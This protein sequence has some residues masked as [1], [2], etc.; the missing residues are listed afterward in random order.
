MTF[1]K[2]IIFDS[3]SLIS[4]TMAGLIPE[5]RGLKKIFKGKF[6]ITNEVKQ[7]LVDKPMNNKRFELEAMKIQQLLDEKILELPISLGI[8]NS[9]I[10]NEGKKFS[11]IAN[12]TFSTRKGPVKLIHVGESSSLALS[13]I[14]TRKGI[15]NVIA[16]DERTTRM[17]GEKPEN[18]KK[19]M[20]KK[21]HMSIKTNTQNYKFFKG[22]NFIRS[23]ELVYVA[24]KK[25]I[26]R[27]KKGPVLDALLYALKFKGAAISSDEI[28]EIKRIN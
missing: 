11:D 13:K 4:F 10:T 6:L 19:L 9:E 17:L 28:N 25:K 7:E 16:I 22:F 26:V 2:S 14:L 20:E 3:G 23:P 18:L 12:N 1:Q 8:N 21:L 27:F 15:R 5:L 24:Y